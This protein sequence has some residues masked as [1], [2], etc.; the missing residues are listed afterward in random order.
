MKT[1]KL[2][3]TALVM[4][5]LLFGCGASGLIYTHTMQPLTLD[6]HKTPVVP[7]SGEGDIKHIHFRVVE[8]AWGSNAI[9]DIARKKGLR[10]LYFADLETLK[11]LGI[12]NQYTVHVYGK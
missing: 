6:M 2:L 3:S 7:T 11:I 8:V 1:L 12:W 10:E 5:A 4:A 9:E